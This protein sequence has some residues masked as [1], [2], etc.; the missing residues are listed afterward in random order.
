MAIYIESRVKR[1]GK[2]PENDLSYS[3]TEK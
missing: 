2:L 1:N 3:V